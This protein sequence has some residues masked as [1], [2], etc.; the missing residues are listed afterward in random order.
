M[1]WLLKLAFIAWV[2]A[3][4]LFI[5]GNTVYLVTDSLPLYT[6]GFDKYGI[7][8]KTGIDQLQLKQIATTLIKYFD[9]KIE[10]P[11]LMVTNARGIFELYS[12]K[13]LMH[14]EDVRTIIKVFRVVQ[15]T[16]GLLLV[17][18]GVL[19]SLRMRASML[20]RGLQYGSVVLLGLMAVLII[21]SLI[22]FN[23]LFYL[24]HIVSFSNDLWL[25]DPSRDYLIMM[26][27]EGFFYDASIFFMVIAIVQSVALF[28]PGL[29]VD[30][31][32]RRHSKL[33]VG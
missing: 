6:H 22:D 4:P 9:G 17:L 25:L 13:E 1:N 29:I 32:K 8:D 28:L 24:F 16:A 21:W 30:L 18:L 7:S 2:L 12:S 3:I 26:F 5:I 14:L 11:Q 31:I 27:P 15:I 19:I 33:E 10:T 23:S 20:F